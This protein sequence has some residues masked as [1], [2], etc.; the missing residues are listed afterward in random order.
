ML[1]SL[2]DEMGNQNLQQ[3]GK[4]RR[5]LDELSSLEDANFELVEGRIS[6]Q[7]EVSV[8][9]ARL[10]YLK[11]DVEIKKHYV[12]EI[13]AKYEERDLNKVANSYDVDY[14]MA[15]VAMLTGCINGRLG[16]ELLKNFSKNLIN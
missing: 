1:T 10:N 5:L 14:L 11:K 6:L 12:E 3:A 8:L 4:I 15:K 7:M 9:K 16:E 13:V 2:V